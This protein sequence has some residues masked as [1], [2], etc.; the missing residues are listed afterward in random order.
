MRVPPP[1][2]RSAAD[3][4]DLALPGS[5]RSAMVAHEGRLLGFLGRR[6]FRHVRVDDQTR[7]RLAAVGEKG[8]TVFVLR[9]RS[10][11]DYLFFNWLFLQ[12]GA[13]LA[14]L[15]NGVDLSFLK[16]L[17]RWF[18]ALTARILGRADPDSEPGAYGRVLQA[19]GDAALLFMK[20]RVWL[21]EDRP[22]DEGILEALIAAQRMQDTA[23]LLLP[24]H[25]AWP[26]KPPSKQRT[27]RDALFGGDE[28]VGRLRKLFHFVYHRKSATVQVGEPID[29]RQALA[30]HPDWTD[31]R[32]ARMVRRVLY[33][34]LAREAMAIHGP[35]VKSPSLIR[36]EIVERKA[37]RDELRVLAEQRG[38]PFSTAYEQARKDLREVAAQTRFGIVVL[39]GRVLDWLFNRVFQGI[40]VD[41]AGMRRVK[42]AARLSRRA[43]LILVPSHKSHIDY[44]VISYVFLRNDFI[45]PHIAAGANLSFFPV[46][47]LL[48]RAGAFFLRRTLQGQPFYKLVFRRYLWKLVRE[49]Y[50]VEFFMEGGRSRTGKLLPPKMGMLAMLLEG[51]RLG[52][53]KDLQFVPINLS[54][55]RVVET[56]S[57]KRELTGGEKKSESVGGVVKAGKVLRSRYGRI[58]VTFEEPVRLTEY[59]AQQGF[60][61][62]GADDASLRHTTQKLAWHLMRQVQEATIV[63]PSMLVGTVLMSHDRRGMS[64]RR[65]R[66]RVGFLVQVLQRRNARLSRSIEHR[67]SQSVE[68]IERAGPAHGADAHRARGEVLKPLLDE[69]LGL[70]KRLVTRLDRGGEFI[71]T[72]PEKS[73]IELDY[74]RNAVLSILAPEAILSTAL[75]AA[76]RPVP[77]AQLAAEVARLSHWF[78]LEF[79]YPTRQSF[80]ANFTDTLDGLVADELV[81]VGEDGLVTAS[82]PLAL[83][84]FAG[85]LRHLV[86]GY[87][88]AA[89][90]LRALSH[91]PQEKAEWLS[92][93]R[94]HAE[95]EFLDGDVHRPES[96]STAVLGNALELFLQEGLIRVMERAGGRKPVKV[97][98]LGEGRGLEDVAFR[99][100]DLG[101]FLT[102]TSGPPPVAVAPG[103]VPPL[104]Q[105]PEPIGAEVHDVPRVD[106]VV[107]GPDPVP[108]A[109]PAPAADGAADAATS[110]ETEGA[111]GKAEAATPA[112]AEAAA[113]PAVE[114]EGG[115]LGEDASGTAPGSIK[116]GK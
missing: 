86:E 48:R 24:Q 94:E 34:H 79:V 60:Q 6:V 29:L 57:Y 64:D 58:Y 97:Y 113:E 80:E 23:I 16:G 96:A 83:E 46:G 5:A 63:A 44:L 59:L 41:A 68:R 10:L 92:Y 111:E 98:A 55:E 114:A 71:Y 66:D 54:Y 115:S 62:A 15:A 50:P 100:D 105:A 82:A 42:E 40:E 72:V 110:A 11:L 106:G 21:G 109:A 101:F 51:V 38:I 103:T 30:D 53:F 33:I 28:A 20:R 39:W 116:L 4:R 73:R 45:P 104:T 8:Q 85:M 35:K 1:P 78:R 27:W 95:R 31:A 89:D 22:D 7:A 90:A 26:R 67:L 14:R 52:E 49:G 9:S 32:L 99:R 3:P 87:W 112:E 69:A 75:L 70:L 12:I 18:D 74:Y 25:I 93:A 17:R 77:R 47:P 102:G 43:P 36:R 19:P 65:L 61:V 76:G 91:G 84:F 107:I 37:F 81:T 13:P 88:I 2:V 56:A 108:E